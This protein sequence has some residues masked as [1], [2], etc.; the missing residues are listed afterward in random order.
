MTQNFDSTDRVLPPR[1][2]PFVADSIA[3]AA[4]ASA[5]GS[6]VSADI[7][8]FTALSERL[9][10]H[11]REGAEELTVLLN[12]CFGGMIEIIDRNGGDVLKFGG[13]ALLVLFEGPEH[14]ARAAAACFEMRTLI[15][16]RWSTALVKRIE[17]GISQ[18]IHSGTFDLHLVDAGHR[19]LLV[20]GPGMSATVNCEGA[21]ERGQILLSHAAAALLEPEFL[22]VETPE[23]RALDRAP[24]V[25]VQRPDAEAGDDLP[26]DP[27]V[28]D[29]LIEQ[30]AAGRVAEHRTV[31]VG[32]VFFGGIDALMESEGPA[33][34]QDRLQAL[35]SAVREATATHEVYWLASDVYAGGGKII[36]TAGAPRST[37]QDEDAAVRAARSSSRSTSVCRF[38]WD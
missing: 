38:G 17:L 22:G 34:V 6:L 30:T 27:F 13:D 28:P 10:A 8:G 7:S 35:A 25:R 29:W 15:E 1:S 23:G 16:R 21:A 12:Q 37:G 3:P 9:A 31:T 18:G 2:R 26:V 36:L 32:F 20:V 14:T 5:Q 4:S 24:E 11:G 33:A 19:E